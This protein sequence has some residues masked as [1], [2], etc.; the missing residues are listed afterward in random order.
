M[1]AAGITGNYHQARIDAAS[2]QHGT[3]Q[4]GTAS[5]QG[6]KTVINDPTTLKRIQAYKLEARTYSRH[7]KSTS[8]QVI[9][10]RSPLA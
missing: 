3:R 6:F 4:G 2:Y 5:S 8:L 7:A 1:L 10:Q 9:M